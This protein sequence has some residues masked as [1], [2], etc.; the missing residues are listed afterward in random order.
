MNVHVYRHPGGTVVIS[1]DA[2]QVVITDPDEL[3]RMAMALMDY[4]LDAADWLDAQKGG[5]T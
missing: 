2:F 3:H 5:A 4:A 1:Q